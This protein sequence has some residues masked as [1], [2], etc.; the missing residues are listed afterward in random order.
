VTTMDRA[1]IG[2][3]LPLEDPEPVSDCKECAALG[4]Q[5]SEARAQGDMSRVSDCNVRMRA[6]HPRQ[7]RRR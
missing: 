1:P 7:K 6:H 4:H 3:S 5:R 2:L